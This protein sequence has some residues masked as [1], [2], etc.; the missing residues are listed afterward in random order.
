MLLSRIVVLRASDNPVLALNETFDVEHGRIDISEPAR[1]GLPVKQ[2]YIITSR[3]A[4]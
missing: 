1:F 3:R 4:A 2:G